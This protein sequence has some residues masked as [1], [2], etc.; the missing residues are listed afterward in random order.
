MT[1]ENADPANV[2]TPAGQETVCA[3]T[4]PADPANVGTPAGQE[5]VCA[6]TVPGDP[7][8]AGTSTGQALVPEGVPALTA[9]VVAEL[10]VNAGA[11]TLPEGVKATV[12]FDPVGVIVSLPPVVPTSPLAASVP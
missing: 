5:T 9:D 2:G 4:V 10:P 6:G 7:A 1:L 3:G 11:A 8:N 12:E